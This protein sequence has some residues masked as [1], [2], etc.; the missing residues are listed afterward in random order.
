MVAQELGSID[1][2]ETRDEKGRLFLLWKEDGNSRGQKTPIWAQQINEERTKLL[3]E[4]TA[5]FENDQEWEGNLVEGVAIF[6]K[7]GF[8]YA[9]YSAR[10]CCEIDCDYVTGVAR[11]KSLLGPW[12]KYDANQS[13]SIMTTGNVRVMGQWLKMMG[14][15]TCF[16]MPTIQKGVCM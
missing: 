9:T 12:E 5:L 8:F 3:G 14:S 10:G 15:F 6:R 7:N 1:A 13:K 4:K 2:F 11:S 16:T